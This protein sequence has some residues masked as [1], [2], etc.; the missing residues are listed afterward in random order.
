MIRSLVFATGNQHKLEEVQG[1]LGKDFALSCLKDVGITEDIPETAMTLHEN[2]LQKARYVYDKCGCACFADDTGL[3][4]EALKGEPGVFSARY[5][6]P[7]KDSSA[8]MQLVLQKMKGESKRQACFRT[9]IAYI[10]STGKEWLFEGRVDGTI[11]E[12]PTGSKGFGYDP[13][14]TPNGYEQTF[15]ELPLSIKNAIGH[16]GKAMQK[17]LDFLN[18]V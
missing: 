9:V 13:I 7:Q 11:I 8:N 10:D 15:A 3:E 18:K 6:G 16:R 2:A 17:F 5:A 1:L 12:H 14:F 4:V